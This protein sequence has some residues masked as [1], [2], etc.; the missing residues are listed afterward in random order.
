MK[1]VEFQYT[2]QELHR[3]LFFLKRELEKSQNPFPILLLEGE[4]G[5]G[6]TTFVSAFVHSFDD[7]LL[8]NS[9]TF[10]L[11][12]EYLTKE[13]MAIYHFDLFRLKHSSDLEELGFEEIWGKKESPLLNGGR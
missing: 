10:T 12:N 1:P 9:P 2:L 11:V 4:M 5:A 3:P 7:T 6:K 13:K 8:V